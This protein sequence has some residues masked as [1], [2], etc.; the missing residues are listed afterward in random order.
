MQVLRASARPNKA[1]SARALRAARCARKP[2]SR[3]SQYRR[4]LLHLSDP[5]SGAQRGPHTHADPQSQRERR[6]RPIATRGRG[7]AGSLRAAFVSVFVSRHV[8][9]ITHSCDPQD[10]VWRRPG[11][12]R[13]FF[14]MKSC[15]RLP[16]RL[17]WQKCAKR[18]STER[19][20]VRVATILRKGAP[21]Y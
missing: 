15:K 6:A 4:F 3:F 12:G 1:D 5:E 21:V 14:E 8:W 13:R 18:V 20:W 7:I 16:L 10:P 9:N 2:Q 17:N 19:L 11:G